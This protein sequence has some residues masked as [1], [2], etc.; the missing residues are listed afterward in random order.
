MKTE[1]SS[2]QIP[3][4]KVSVV[5]ETVNEET[6]PVL[7]L[8]AVLGGL[9]AQTYPS[10]RIEIVVAVNSDNERLKTRL[11]ERPRPLTIVELDGGTYFSMKTAGAHAATG[12]IVAF[13]DSDCVPVADWAES[14]VTR[15]TS[16]FD[17]VAGK[18]RYPEGARFAK[19]FDFFNF[20]Y[21][22]A[23]A[24]GN[25]NTLLPNNFALRREIF[26]EHPFDPRLR[27]GGAGHYLGNRLKAL[28]YKL[29]Y[30]PN[31]RVTHNCY[32]ASDEILMRVKSGFDTVTIAALDDEQVV[33]ETRYLRRSK[34]NLLAIY[35]RRIHFDI[36]AIL[37]NR[38]DL[39]IPLWQAP[40]FLLAS[41]FIRGLEMCAAVITMIKPDYFRKKYGW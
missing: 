37:T 33:D 15:I 9:D 32:E 17:G 36:R 39:G 8:D 14:L 27:R 24:D 16:G 29:V 41:P 3:R 20:G 35:L 2:R 10:D 1:E 21:I 26:L 25:A 38:R 18:T 12:E 30:E 22:H 31:M 34:L 6:G 19:T 13:L 5:I 23:D 4:P 28:G 7:D 40:Y 11:R